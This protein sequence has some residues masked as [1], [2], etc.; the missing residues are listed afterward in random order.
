MT[1]FQ[2]FM[3]W[4]YR[5]QRNIKFKLASRKGNYI[6]CADAYEHYR[7]QKIKLLEEHKI[8]F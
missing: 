1:K 7:I 2:T 3:L 4:L 5:I 6:K 8:I